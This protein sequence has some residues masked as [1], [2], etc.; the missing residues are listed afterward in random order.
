METKSPNPVKVKAGLIGAVKR[1]GAEP[2]VVRLHELT[3]PQ[4]RLVLALIAAARRES[5]GPA[6]A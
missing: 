3:D 5:D 4:R 1:W 6:A 2:S